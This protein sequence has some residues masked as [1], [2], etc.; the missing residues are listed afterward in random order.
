MW[1]EEWKNA[2]NGESCLSVNRVFPRMALHVA[3]A[4]EQCVDN[5]HP[6]GE[7]TP[8][9]PSAVQSMAAL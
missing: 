4:A 7:Q 8:P 5:L 3:S 1:C 9:N 6:W 2:V